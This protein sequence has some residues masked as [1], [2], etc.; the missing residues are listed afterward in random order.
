MIHVR[1]MHRTG[2]Q[3]IEARW[4][5]PVTGRLKT[6]SLKTANRLAAER[7]AAVLEADLNAGRYREPKKVTWEE[8]RKEYEADVFPGQA[9]KTQ[10][11][12]QSMFNAVERLINPR[13]LVAMDT[14]Q[15]RKFRRQLRKKGLV[16]YTVK[17]HLGE[18]RK[19]LRWAIRND[20]LT[21]LPQIGMPRKPGGMK[22]R[23]ITA[24]EFERMLAALPKVV[25]PQL[26]PGS[27]KRLP[28]AQ[29]A[30][31]TARHARA[32]E[33][34]KFLLRGLW[35]S[36]LRLGEALNLHWADDRLLCV[37]LSRKHPMFRIRAQADKSRVERLFLPMAPEFAELLLSV[38]EAGRS[39]HVF[40]PVP[41]K[42]PEHVRLRV[43]WVSKVISAIGEKAGVKV[44]ER[45][46]GP[47][48]ETPETE[49]KYASAHDLR[50]AFGF[51]WALRVMPPVLQ[52]L[53]RHESI[54]TT[55]QFYVG[56]NADVA[57]RAVWDAYSKAAGNAF[58]NTPADEAIFRVEQG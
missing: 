11:K 36:G 8:F 56:R 18:L 2:R 32:T 20:F 58:G 30:A 33:S 9:L 15:I 50:R 5:D 24:E 19:V 22:G 38:P 41:R 34:W 1:L 53:M 3:F 17:G 40:N 16:E 21:S 49:I 47:R 55:M 44:A 39:G 51:R 54:T 46:P 6:K 45:E 35:W 14:E 27:W 12:T 10:W 4:E 48:A 23:P 29:R 57:A 43:D 25:S 42:G 26:S 52:E 37:D 13:L 28:K 31:W 7:L